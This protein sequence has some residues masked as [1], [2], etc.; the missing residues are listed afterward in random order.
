MESAFYN[1]SARLVYEHLSKHK[2]QT[3][4]E[5]GFEV[6]LPN[7]FKRVSAKEGTPFIDSADLFEINPDVTK[8]IAEGE[9]GDSYKGRVLSG[10][11]LLAR[12]G[13]V[14][15]LNGQLVLANKF[16]TNKIVSDHV[17]RIAHK[18]LKG[19][20]MGYV[21]TAL[22]HPSL[23]QPIVK[24][25]AYGSS[26]PE[27]DVV[28]VRT[29]KIVRLDEFIELE[30]SNKAVEASQ[31]FAEADAL[32]NEIAAEAEALIDR[33]LAGEQGEFEALRLVAAPT[34]SLE[35]DPVTGFPPE[36]D[37]ERQMQEWRDNDLSHLG[38]LPPFEWG[39]HGEPEV[40]PLRYVEGEGWV[41]S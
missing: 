37:F 3:L 23:G 33:F 40:H 39:E 9:F 41:T 20:H 12:S 14:Y 22:S 1:P 13:Q 36:T 8:F 4:E 34:K 5:M 35:P 28:D 17:I 18:N 31:L 2:V 21:Y 38:E 16:H 6:W 27:I 11:I 15:G 26:I 7:R 24:S 10:W 19:V 29:L 30:I 32:E 25:L